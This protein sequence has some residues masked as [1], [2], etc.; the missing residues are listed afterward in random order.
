MPKITPK[1]VIADI[2]AAKIM[3]RSVGGRHTGSS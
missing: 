1:I 3:G 2:E